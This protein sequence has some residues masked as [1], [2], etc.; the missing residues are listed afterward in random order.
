MTLVTRLVW[1]LRR[2]RAGVKRVEELVD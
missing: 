2:G 1:R